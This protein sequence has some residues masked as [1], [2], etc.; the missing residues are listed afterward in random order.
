MFW[1]SN[2]TR[3]YWGIKCHQS[4]LGRQMSI[5]V[6]GASNDTKAYWGVKCHP[7]LL[8]R[9]MPPQ[10]YWGVKGLGESK[11]RGVKGHDNL[12]VS[13]ATTLFGPQYTIKRTR[14]I[15]NFQHSP[16]IT[17]KMVSICTF[18]QRKSIS[19]RTALDMPRFFSYKQN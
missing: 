18:K 15:A 3:G 9:Q 11:G 1:V 17:S 19:K 7:R 12:K 2:A 16:L 14:E 10:G 6:I 13:M 8:G 5:E 4:L